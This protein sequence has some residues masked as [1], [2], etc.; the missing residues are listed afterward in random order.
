MEAM[1]GTIAAED[2]P[3]GGLT[4]VIELDQARVGPAVPA[5][6]SVAPAVTTAD[7][8]TADQATADQATADQATVWAERMRP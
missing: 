7:Q 4:I 1:G 8:A 3:G 5:A 6:P 2:T